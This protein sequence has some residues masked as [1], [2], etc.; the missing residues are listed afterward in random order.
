MDIDFLVQDTYS[1]T[2]PQWKL[3]TDLEEAT[4]LFSEAVAQNFK[5]QDSE[6]PVEPDED[7]A[8]SS[9]SDDDLEEDAMPEV[10]EEQES[11]DEAEVGS[12]ARWISIMLNLSAGICPQR[13]AQ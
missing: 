6:R 10:D 1:M 5:T 9:S 3:A 4:A 12:S 7:D 2:R 11:S 13:R 8:E